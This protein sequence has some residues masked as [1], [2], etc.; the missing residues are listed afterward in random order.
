MAKRTQDRNRRLGLTV[1]IPKTVKGSPAYLR[2]KYEDAMTLVAE[3]G[4]PDLFITFTGNR[5]WPEIE[6]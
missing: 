1:T 4:T 3:Y 2:A 5:K 6:V